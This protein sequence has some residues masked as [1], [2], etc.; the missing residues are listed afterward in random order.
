[1]LSLSD[2]FSLYAGEWSIADLSEELNPT[3]E[4]L[5]VSAGY[6]WR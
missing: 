1:M 6:V 4:R 5:K 3:I 2:E